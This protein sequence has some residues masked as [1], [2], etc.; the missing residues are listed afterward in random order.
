MSD[1]LHT[2]VIVGGG[3]GGLELATRLGHRLGKRK[4]ARILW[5]DAHLINMG[6]PLYDEVA[7]ASL[8]SAAL[9]VNSRAHGKRH[10]FEFSFG[11]LADIDRA[12]DEVSLAPTLH[13][14]GEAVVPEL[15]KSHDTVV[16]AVGS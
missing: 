9:A 16:V 13:K 8:D 10:H 14:A 15:R 7:S 12:R 5:I 6:K 3:A 4:R 1:S 2:I 11:Y